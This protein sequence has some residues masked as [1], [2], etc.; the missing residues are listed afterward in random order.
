[1]TLSVLIT[2]TVAVD[3][4]KPGAQVV[5][6]LQ[7]GD[8]GTR[9]LRLVP[10]EGGKAVDL[11][12]AAQAKVMAHSLNNDNDLLITAELG[13]N[14]VDM[15]PTPALVEAADEFACQLLI[16]DGEGQTL[17]SM[18]FTV[19]VHGSVYTGDAVEHTD[20]T[21]SSMEWDQETM[22]LRLIRA[23]GTSITCDM[24]HTHPLATE[25][26]DGFMSKEMFS[27]LQQLSEWMDQGVKTT[28]S[29]TFAG[30]QIG[31]IIIE[32]NEIRNARFT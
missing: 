10:T 16:L 20:T 11:S 9:A 32:N 30:L 28:D 6:H 19:L 5:V 18:P 21:I 13:E 26:I 17:K 31:D 12:E 3:A 7:Q 25:E 4:Q 23:D 15:V 2:T 1:M 14:Y 22:T 27:L 24:T 8:S 29:P